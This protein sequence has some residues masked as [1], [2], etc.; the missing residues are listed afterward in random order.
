MLCC[1]KS[2]RNARFLL[3]WVVKGTYTHRHVMSLSVFVCPPFI[4]P[5]Y[6]ATNEPPAVAYSIAKTT[7]SIL[8]LSQIFLLS[9]QKI[10]GLWE[11][12]QFARQ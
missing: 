9:R 4:W 5:L 6:F 1:H 12:I 7:L 2:I 8:P 3:Y 10:T 11:N